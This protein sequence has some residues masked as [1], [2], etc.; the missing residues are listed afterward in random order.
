VSASYGWR[1]GDKL[2]SVTSNFPGESSVTY[3]YGG[4]QKRRERTAA[5]T[6]VKYN[7]DVGW[8]LINQETSGG[9]LAE[10]YVIENP[11][12][13]VSTLLGMASG[14]NPSTGAYAYF[15]HD[16]LG[17]VRSVYDAN[18]TATGDY[19]YTPYGTMY[20]Q[21]GATALSDLPAAFTGKPLDPATGM[22]YFPYRM[23]SPQLARWLWR[24][25]LGQEFGPNMYCYVD[26]RPTAGVDPL[27]AYTCPDG[28]QGVEAGRKVYMQT[29][30]IIVWTV[31]YECNRFD[32]DVFGTCFGQC[33]AGYTVGEA[34]ATAIIGAIGT[35]SMGITGFISTLWQ[36]IAASAVAGSVSIT[37]ATGSLVLG[38]GG[39]YVVITC[40]S[41]CQDVGTLAGTTLHAT[42]EQQ[43]K[44]TDIWDWFH[45]IPPR[46][47]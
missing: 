14:S 36:A 46:M 5:G 23:Y 2:Y 44:D 13:Q 3:D 39:V 1:Y 29:A 30:S 41:A 12:A 7:W 26:G 11:N 22:Y 8:N 32:W 4:D 43:E 17:S 42:R 24:D 31:V 10:T 38:I 35:T 28:S 33:M 16:H 27:G 15:A 18:K 21:A 34:V 19:A 6:T 40:L 20:A 9:A 37:V 25:P 45:P 47:P